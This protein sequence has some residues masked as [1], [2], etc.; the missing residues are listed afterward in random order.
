[1]TDEVT[2]EINIAHTKLFFIVDS[3]SVDHIL[4]PDYPVDS[5]FA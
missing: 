2:I 5:P 1:M 3:R 4:P